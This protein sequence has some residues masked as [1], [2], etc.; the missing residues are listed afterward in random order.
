M[1]IPLVNTWVAAQP[2]RIVKMAAKWSGSKP[3]D[4]QVCGGTLGSVF[5]DAAM[6]IGQWALMC[7]SCFKQYGTGLGTGR[8]QKYNTKTLEKVAG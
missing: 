7:N 3:T 1:M 8:G 6:K 4:C 5:Y 2:E